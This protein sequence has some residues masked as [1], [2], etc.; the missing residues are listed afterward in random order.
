MLQRGEKIDDLVQKSD[1]LSAQSKMFYRESRFLISPLLCGP[2]STGRTVTALLP[3]SSQ[4]GNMYKIFPNRSL[5]QSKQRS[6]TVAAS[7]CEGIGSHTAFST[8]E[9]FYPYNGQFGVAAWFGW[10]SLEMLHSFSDWYIL[11]GL[12]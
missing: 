7:S 6:R 3:K 8:Y 5:M 9:G 11:T 12:R 4:N 1:G 10:N 2:H